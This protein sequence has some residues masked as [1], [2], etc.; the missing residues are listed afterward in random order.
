M[1]KVMDKGNCCFIRRRDIHFMHISILPIVMAF[2]ELQNKFLQDKGNTA[3]MNTPLD[4]LEIIEQ[5]PATRTAKAKM[6]KPTK[7]T[8]PFLFKKN[9]ICEITGSMLTTSDSLYT[10]QPKLKTGN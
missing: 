4:Q 1:A 5:T 9:K 8:H 10:N 6:A 2:E 3:R 7:T